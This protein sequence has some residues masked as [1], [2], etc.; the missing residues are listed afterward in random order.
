MNNTVKEIESGNGEEA[1][2]FLAVCQV[3]IIK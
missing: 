3:L 2:F 1:E